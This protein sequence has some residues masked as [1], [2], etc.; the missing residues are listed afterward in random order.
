M[1]VHTWMK[2]N[3]DYS[4]KLVHSAVE[5]ACSGEEAFL[6]GQPLPEFAAMSTRCALR[7][8]ALGALIG[9]V[10]SVSGRKRHPARMLA[11]GFL[12][13]AIGF[14]AGFVWQSRELV[15]NVALTA[16]NRIGNVRDEHWFEK[17]PIDYA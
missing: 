1:S 9:I 5:G 4:R 16:W 7:P 8:A 10:G 12:G 2:S 3:A 13:G 14:A 6:H 11:Y 17:N 15:E